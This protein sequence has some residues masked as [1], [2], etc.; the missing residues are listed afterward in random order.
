M[1]D[2]FFSTV[3]CSRLEFRHVNDSD[4]R[5]KTHSPFKNYPTSRKVP[6]N[7]IGVRKECKV[8]V[9]SVA[10]LVFP[11]TVLCHEIRCSHKAFD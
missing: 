10:I 4:S 3:N 5:L 2:E 11:P 7:L 8:V 6:Q 9:F 1:V